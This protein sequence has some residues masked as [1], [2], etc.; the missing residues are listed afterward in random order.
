MEKLKQFEITLRK[1][2]PFFS[3]IVNIGLVIC[4]VILG[5]FWFFMI[6]ADSSASSL[7]MNTAYFIL[8]VPEW[9]KNLTGLACLSF[10]V[11]LPLS[12]LRQKLPAILILNDDAIIIKSKFKIYN[13]SYTTIHQILFNDLKDQS[14][15][16]KGKLQVAIN[17]RSTIDQLPLKIVFMLNDYQEGG[18]V[19]EMANKVPNIDFQMYDTT[20]AAFFDNE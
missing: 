7:E 18:E 11:L 6:P 3:N 13:I 12:M 5:L 4:F 20:S 2:I 19:I 8:A 10:I 14:G 9:V 16:P 15:F 17:Y 1:P